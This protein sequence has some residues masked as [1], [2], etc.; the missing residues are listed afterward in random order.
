VEIDRRQFIEV[1]SGAAAL[2][3]LHAQDR[4]SGGDDPLGV[5]HDFPVVGEGLYLNSAYIAPV[6]LPVAAAARAFAER[7]ATKPIRLDEMLKTTDEVRHQVA[8]L[9]GAAAEEVG[10][11][12]ATSEGENI[13]AAALD[14]KAGDNVVIDE[15]HYETSFVLYRH[16]QQ[17]R[18][19]ALRIV[20]HRDGSVA[21]DDFAGAVD[22]RTRLVS[23][24]WV[25]HQ[26]GFRHEMRPRTGRCSTPMRCRRSACSRWTFGPR[27]SIA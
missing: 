11:L 22:D 25:S 27:E 16:L 24:A 5:R 6:P 15:L 17:T 8:R 23:V 9:L 20:K 19:I 1:A 7:K 10:F 18:G 14:L 3:P 2:L 12:Y 13:V 21:R 4:A 26:N